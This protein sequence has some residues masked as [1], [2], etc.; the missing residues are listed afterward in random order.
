MAIDS[1]TLTNRHIV[2]NRPS[3]LLFLFSVLLFGTALLGATL[4][5]AFYST[6]LLFIFVTCTGFWLAH[7]T[8][9]KLKDP[10]LRILSSFWLVN[11]LMTLFL[12]YLGW[13][14]MLDPG[15]SSW[16]YDPQRF[17]L[18]AQQLLE[19]NW[20]TAGVGLNFFGIV[21]FYAAIL[22]LFGINPVTPALVNAFVLLFGVLF[23]IRV[24]YAA[25][26]V[27]NDKSHR[28]AW[29]ILVPEVLWFDV[30][31][32]RETLMA[33][34]LS[35]AILGAGAAMTSALSINLFRLSIFIFALAGILLV[36][37][38]MIL[39]VG[40]S[41]ALISCI[42]PYG[43]RLNIFVRA[44]L[45]AV[46][47]FALSL[48][49]SIQG[50]I[51]GTDIDFLRTFYS[52]Q[53][54][55]DN[56]ASS[57][58]HQWSDNSIGLLLA[59]NN[60][61]EALVFLPPRMVLYLASPLPNVAVSLD[62]LVAGEWH[63]WQR[64]MTIPT[65]ALILLGFPYVLAGTAHAWRHRLRYPLLTVIPIGFWVVFTVVAGGNII[66]HERYRLMSTLLLFA[67]MWIGFTQS[68]TSLTKKWAVF[69]YGLLGAMTCLYIAFKFF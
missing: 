52:I 34:L 68:S 55:E 64:L 18:Y 17:Y 11:V 7:K 30:M 43:R 69:W 67:T 45:F 27:I 61:L 51:G 14:P 21:Y 49:P 25:S 29:L 32:S 37:T 46:F 44:A 1:S 33:V 57:A 16:G 66:I 31:T 4:D 28:L 36:R 65:S 8:A 62:A 59:P 15:S 40:S 9:R 39:A 63:E 5:E 19:N 42:T 22:L 54:F 53:S 35:V 3:Q 2:A 50:M 48:A 26:P 13:M 10:R 12:L 23:I 60:L 56:V 47:V 58:G 41:L 24:A 20:N 38:S 6:L